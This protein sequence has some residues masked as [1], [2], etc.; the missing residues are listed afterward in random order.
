MPLG[1]EVELEQLREL[2][3]ERQGVARVQERAQPAVLALDCLGP[4][5]ARR[6]ER[7]LA[8]H[9][10]MLREQALAVRE[11]GAEAFQPA[12]RRL[13]REEERMGCERDR[14]AQAREPGAAGI[15]DHQGDR[16]QHQRQHPQRGGRVLLE[17]RFRFREALVHDRGAGRAP[18]ASLLTRS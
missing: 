11:P 12:H 4:L 17:G 7:E 18:P 5:Q 6:E 10:G 13:H 9:R 14:L 3:L 8:P 2:D 1:A 16:E 15:E